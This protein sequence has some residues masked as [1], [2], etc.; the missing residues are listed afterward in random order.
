VILQMFLMHPSVHHVLV[1]LNT[2]QRR[3]T[4]DKRPH[5]QSHATGAAC[6]CLALSAPERAGDVMPGLARLPIEK[7]LLLL[8]LLPL[9]LPL[10]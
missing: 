3:P 7:Q 1:G 9:T 10:P 4:P 8:L 6:R 2:A 5:R